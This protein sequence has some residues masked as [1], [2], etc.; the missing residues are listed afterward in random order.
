MVHWLRFCA[1]TVREAQ[2]WSLVGELRPACLMVWPKIKK[3][4]FCLKFRSMISFV[5]FLP[6]SCLFISFS[7]EKQNRK[8]YVELWTWS[9]IVLLFWLFWFRLGPSGRMWWPN[10]SRGIISLCCCFMQIPRVPQ[11]PP[12]TFPPKLSS[13][14]TAGRATIVK[15]Q[16]SRPALYSSPSPWPCGD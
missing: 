6:T 2:V 11:C 4:N 5:V 13:S 15:I 10:A 7:L 16:V 8:I 12:R 14:H 3:K 1:F 9:V